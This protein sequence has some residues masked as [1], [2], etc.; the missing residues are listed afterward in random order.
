[1]DG[2][3]LGA[4][5]GGAADGAQVTRLERGLPAGE[6]AK[7]AK[8]AL[9]P[10]YGIESGLRQPRPTTLRMALQALEK[11]PKLPEI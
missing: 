6:L 7:K 8:V 2:K 10:I 3:R 9:T 11:I 5:G 1:M 4:G